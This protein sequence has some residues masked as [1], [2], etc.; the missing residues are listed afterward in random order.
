MIGLLTLGATAF[1]WWKKEGEK[2]KEKAKAAAEAAATEAAVEEATFFDPETWTSFLFAL[3]SLAENIITILLFDE[4]AFEDWEVFLAFIAFAVLDTL[5]K[6]FT[7][8]TPVAAAFIEVTSEAVQAYVY[9]IF[10]AW[11]KAAITWYTVLGGVQ[12]SLLVFKHRQIYEPR[13][14]DDEK[15]QDVVRM[16]QI[17]CAGEHKCTANVLSG[18]LHFSLMT[19]K[20]IVIWMIVCIIIFWKILMA[21]ANVFLRIASTIFMMIEIVVLAAKCTAEVFLGIASTI[22]MIIGSVVMAAS[23]AS[24][25]TFVN[26]IVPPYVAISAIGVGAAIMLVAAKGYT[27]YTQGNYCWLS[28]FMFFDLLVFLG[29]AVLAFFMFRS[30]D[31]VSALNKAG[32]VN[33]TDTVQKSIATLVLNGVDSTYNACEVPPLSVDIRPY[34]TLPP[35]N[36]NPLSQVRAIPITARVTWR[37]NP[38]CRLRSIPC[39]RSSFLR[40]SSS[41]W[42]ATR[43]SGTPYLISSMATAW[44]PRTLCFTSTPRCTPTSRLAS[45]STR[46]RTITMG[47]SPGATSTP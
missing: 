2:R 35:T 42:A 23:I 15:D 4:D 43:P 14:P 27:G 5:V 10:C 1:T 41:R 25:V 9:M 6:F 21:T 39:H 22:F 30:Q 46:T 28:V 7:A 47:P 8:E 40:A 37:A 12:I 20:T 31:A 45:S 24:H 16:D 18:L 17:L 19:M 32:Y 33:I 3:I 29:V 11:D 44:A 26:Q 13:E 38:V 34:F 36:P